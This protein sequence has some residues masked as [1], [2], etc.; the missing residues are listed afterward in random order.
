MKIS[1]GLY[2]IS[3]D[4]AFMAIGSIS[5]N[6]YSAFYHDLKKT[7][8]VGVNTPPIQELMADLN[9]AVFANTG[10]LAGKGSAMNSAAVDDMSKQFDNLILGFPGDSDSDEEPE[11]PSPPAFS[12]SD[13][14]APHGHISPHDQPETPSITGA[15]SGDSNVPR[16]SLQ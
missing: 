12:L 3:E 13:V 2:M 10:V 8:I 6:P 16:E 5:K 11:V 7:L 9:K 4:E 1:Q 14:A 15:L